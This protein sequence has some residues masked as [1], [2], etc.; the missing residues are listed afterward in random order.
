MRPYTKPDNRQM[1]MTLVI[2]ACFLPAC[3]QDGHSQARQALNAQLTERHEC[4]ARS[5][6]QYR[7]AAMAYEKNDLESA[8]SH[9]DKAIQSYSRNAE[10]WMLLGL[11]EQKEDRVFEAASSFHRASLLAPDRYEPLYN[12]GILLESFGRYRQAI[13]SYQAALKLSPE[14]LEVMENLARCHIRSGTNLDQARKLIDQALLA[15]RRP[16]WRQWLSQQSHQLAMRKSRY[17]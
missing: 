17:Q 6:E 14:Q 8:R 5:L 7:L 10:A 11:I 12:I 13:E 2:F 16:Q 3:R 9:I 1:A 15:E 4:Q